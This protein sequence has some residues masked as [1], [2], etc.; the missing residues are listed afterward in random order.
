MPREL[1]PF[2]ASVGQLI[3]RLP[4]AE[5]W[6]ILDALQRLCEDPN[7]LD[8]REEDDEQFIVVARYLVVVELN[9]NVLHLGRRR[10]IDLLSTPTGVEMVETFQ[11]Q[12]EHG[13]YV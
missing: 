5:R 3:L 6:A 10:P 13:V 1:G 8:L 4:I 2:P 9:S 12:I 11:T 7:L